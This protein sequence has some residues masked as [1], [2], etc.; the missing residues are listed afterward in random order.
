MADGGMTLTIDETLAQRLRDAAQ[1]AGE[2]V[3]TYARQ[4]LEAFAEGD[5]DWDEIDGICDQTNAKAD[6]LPLEAITPWLNGW[7][8]PDGP[9][10]PR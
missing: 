10:R 5:V 3:E 2:S 9:P 6:G 1:S 7:G 4:A 8:K